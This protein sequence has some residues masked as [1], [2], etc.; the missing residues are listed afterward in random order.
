MEKIQYNPDRVY[1]AQANQAGFVVSIT[2]EEGLVGL[3]GG[4]GK[5]INGRT[6]QAIQAIKETGE[7]VNLSK[8][9]ELGKE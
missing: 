1:F 3:F 8:V 6:A 2:E 9:S 5:R 4:T 7:D